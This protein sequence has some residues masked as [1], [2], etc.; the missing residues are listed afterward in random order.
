MLPNSRENLSSAVQVFVA[1]EDDDIRA[2]IARA[3]RDRGHVVVECA[4]GPTLFQ[5][6]ERRL[7]HPGAR[8]SIVIAQARLPGVGGLRVLH[9]LRGLDVQIPMVLLT[10][11]ED[12]TVHADAVAAGA[13]AVLTKPVQLS[14]LRRVVDALM[15]GVA[16]RALGIPSGHPAILP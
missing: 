11:L 2:E 3:L 1:E 4:D 7:A 14:E 6:L 12:P 13:A 10:W 9:S 16:L 15:A 5:R 8:R